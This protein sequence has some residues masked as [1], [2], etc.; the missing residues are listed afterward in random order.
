M[1][2]VQQPQKQQMGQLMLKRFSR[3]RSKKLTLTGLD[4]AASLMLNSAK[5]RFERTREKATEAFANKALE[6]SD[7]VTAM[8]YRVMSTT[9]ETGDNPADAIAACKVCIEDLHHVPGVK[10]SVSLWS[11]RE[12]SGLARRTQENHFHGNSCQFAP[13]TMSHL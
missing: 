7:R 9:L 1:I 10:E 6:L 13:S 12:A 2:I 8:Q 11:L 5:K 4:D 3:K